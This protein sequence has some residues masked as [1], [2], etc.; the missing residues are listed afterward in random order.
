MSKKTQGETFVSRR[1]ITIAVFIFCALSVPLYA[2]IVEI[3]VVDADLRIPLEGASVR[4]YDGAEYVCDSNGKVVL[5]IPDERPVL[6][7]VAYPGY[8]SGRLTVSSR[9]S[10]YTLELSLSGVMESRELVVEAAKPGSSESRTGQ[11][12]AVSSREI[13]QTAEIGIIE[14][15][16]STIKLLPGV[17]YTGMFNAQPS[18]RGGTPGDMSAALDG[19]YISNPYHWGGGFS[20]FDPKMIQSARL[21]H[22]VFS[23]RYGHTISGLLELSSKKPS[24]S[25]TEFE[26]GLNTSAANFNLSLPLAAKGGAAKGDT[27]KGG[28]LFMGRVTYYDPVVLAAQQLSKVI[29]ILQIINSVS[30]APYIRSA[31]VTA[32]YRLAD[33]LEFKASGFWGMDGVGAVYDTGNQKSDGY[34]SRTN[35]DFSWTNYQGFLTTSLA[36]NPRNDMLL[37]FAMGTGYEDSVVAGDMR[38]RIIGKVF[39]KTDANRGYYDLIAGLNGF[40]DQYDFSPQSRIDQSELMFNAQGRIDYD[41]EAGA[42][43]IVAAGVQELFSKK[44]TRGIQQVQSEKILGDMNTP[45]QEA[46]FTALGLGTNSADT[47]TRNFLKKYMIVSFPLDY[48]P[49]AGNS[50]F[51]TSGYVLSEYSSPNKRVNGELGL[52]LDHYYLLG[53]GFTLQSKPALNP[54]LSVNVNILNTSG[55]I[56]SLDMSAGTGLFASMSDSVFSAEKQYNISEI[57]ANRSWTSVLG[58]KLRFP[59]DTSLTVEG[60]YKYIFDRMYIPITVNTDSFDARPYFN[61]EGKA[62]GIDLMIQKTQSRFVDGWISYSFNWTKYRDPDAG[63]SDMG[64]SGGIYGSDWYFPSYHRFHNLNLILNFKPA[65]RFNIY[66]RFGVAT[67]VVLLKRDSSGPLSYPVYVYDPGNPNGSY[68][69]EKF[70]WPS[71]RDENNRTTASL[72]FDIKFSILGYSKAGKT[73]YEVY[74]AVENIL[75]LVYSAEG[76]T[77]YNQYTGKEETGSAAASYEIPIPIPS[78][79]FKISY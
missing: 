20:I 52:R 2:H 5:N 69:I 67:G 39:E 10:V 29:E 55:F 63:D 41:W 12:V 44:T 79:G 16:M 47:A 70:Y 58:I 28:V 75:A 54:R 9:G 50:L 43:F 59:F 15:V 4:N 14:D 60:Y 78:F 33:N 53:N 18:I 76:N 49:N 72:P 24:P 8:T 42:G 46:I 57:K 19:F 7:Q 27:A 30:V 61:G 11:S 17:G 26:L 37:K 64:I 73:R 56:E 68:F 3:T 71:T 65:P 51:S 48:P 22:G 32:D 6:I 40:K 31:T 66:T 77:S 23:S 36:W 25:E 38:N 34:T 35:I 1:A 13:A 62:W 45:E 21:S 74:A